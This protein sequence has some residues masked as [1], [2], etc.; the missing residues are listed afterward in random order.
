M[1]YH[2][3]GTLDYCESGACIIDCCGV[4]YKLTVSDNTYADVCAHVGERMKLF[5]YLQVREDG[6]ELFGFKTSEELGAFKLLI[7]VSGVG[8]KA[9]M[10]ILSLF[11]A[12]KLYEAICAE[13]VKAISRASGVGAKTAARVV[14]ELRDKVAKQYYGASGIA[15]ASASSSTSSPKSARSNLSEALDALVVL[16]Y[17]R[18]EAQKALTGIDPALDVEKIIPLALAKLM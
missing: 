1:I 14:L 2:V 8:P 13:D 10:A 6:V 7:T 5:T 4:G 18:A 17:S 15:M 9:A 12:S 3:D 16:G 11:S